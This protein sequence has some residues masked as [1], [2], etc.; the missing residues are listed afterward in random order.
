MNKFN[1][2]AR[3]I[4]VMLALF[5][6]YMGFETLCSDVSTQNIPSVGESNKDNAL[7]EV[8]EPILIE[9][10]T[11]AEKIYQSGKKYA[12]KHNKQVARDMEWFVKSAELGDIYAAHSLGDWYRHQR[13]D[14]VNAAKFYTIA[15]EHGYAR[16]QYMLGWQYQQGFGVRQ[17]YQLAMKLYLS[18]AK[19][20]NSMAMFCLG[21]LYAEGLGVEQS[22]TKAVEWYEKSLRT[23]GN[24]YPAY[25][26]GNIYKEGVLVER[27]YYKAVQY[28]TIPAS[29]GYHDAPTK[30]AWFYRTGNGVKQDHQKATILYRRGAELNDEE[31]KKVLREFYPEAV[32]EIY[33]VKQSELKWLDKER[34]SVLEGQYK[35][36]VL[37]ISSDSIEESDIRKSQVFA[38]RDNIEK[39]F[40]YINLSKQENK[41]QNA[42][43][44]ELLRNAVEQAC[45]TEGTGKMKIMDIAQL[46][47]Q[48]NILTSQDVQTI[49]QE[50]STDMGFERFCQREG[51]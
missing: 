18:A 24:M 17:D 26:L 20:G 38:V 23:D 41:Y 12:D 13:E 5:F 16:A 27:D 44:D 45:T 2:I 6:F 15:A 33:W 28:Y 14:Y 37:I 29:R 4:L 30:L 34:E 3:L 11:D 35:Q 40:M 7:P 36:Q 25:E 1:L 19:Q 46:L 47:E 32:Q 10:N 21:R 8:K 42:Y 39:L 51:R 49:M 50:L 48:N 9:Q 43:Y 22:G 31:A